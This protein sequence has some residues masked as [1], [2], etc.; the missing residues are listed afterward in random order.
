MMVLESDPRTKKTQRWLL[1]GNSKREGLVDSNKNVIDSI[2]EI[3]VQSNQHMRE[4]SVSP[5]L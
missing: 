2:G 3:K 5:C 4:L 1:Y